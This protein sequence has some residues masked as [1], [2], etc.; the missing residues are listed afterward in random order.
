MHQFDK[1]LLAMLSIVVLLHSVSLYSLPVESTDIQTSVEATHDIDDQQVQLK[2][3][4]ALIP[5]FQ[6]IAPMVLYYIHEVVLLNESDY[7][8]FPVQVDY[9]NQFLEVLFPL[10]ISPNAP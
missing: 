6:G 5:S 10:I 1:Y 9:Q 8:E 3:Y 4:D 2:A 7:Q